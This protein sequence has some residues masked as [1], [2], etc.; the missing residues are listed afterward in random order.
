MACWPDRTVCSG[1]AWA[2]A[3]GGRDRCRRHL[4]HPAALPPRWQSGTGSVGV[5]PALSPGLPRAGRRRCGPGGSS[6][7]NHAGRQRQRQ[8]RSRPG[9]TGR[10]RSGRPPGP[11]AAAPS[12]RLADGLAAGRLA[13]GRGGKQPAPGLGPQRPGLARCDRR[14]ALERGPA[15]DLCQRWRAWPV[16]CRGGLSPR[17]AGRLPRGGG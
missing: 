5:G 14:A 12:G 17:P 2:A 6:W 16:G 4:R 8:P 3:A 13:L 1:P 7:C 10:G 15:P 11:L 9:P